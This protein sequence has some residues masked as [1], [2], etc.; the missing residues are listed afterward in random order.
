MSRYLSRGWLPRC[1]G[2][3][4]CGPALALLGACHQSSALNE[5]SPAQRAAAAH[6]EQRVRQFPGVDVSRTRGG[7]VSI[8]LLSAAVSDGR[9]LYVIDGT[10][11]EAS[12]SGFNWFEPEDIL[13]IKVLRNPADAAVYG[14]RGVNG[15]VLVSTRFAR[16]AQR[17]AP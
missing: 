16:R 17:K 8:R 15:V 10:P 4:A 14:P 5:F 1:A 12:S 9:A 6:E 11:V 7:G 3:L 2:V 13:E